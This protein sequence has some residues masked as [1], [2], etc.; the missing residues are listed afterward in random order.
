MTPTIRAPR[1]KTCNCP[2]GH[3]WGEDEIACSA[4]LVKAPQRPAQVYDRS[5]Y[6]GWFSVAYVVKGAWRDCG[7]KHR[8]Q[9]SA[10]KCCATK[11]RQHIDRVATQAIKGVWCVECE[12]LIPAEEY[13][14]GHD[15]EAK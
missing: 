5:G 11:D 2:S 1:F 12:Q 14:Y 13:A 10:S 8:T 4:G 7:H 15:C 6:W 9:A 3:R